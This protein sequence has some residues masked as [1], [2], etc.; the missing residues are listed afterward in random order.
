MTATDHPAAE[1][2]YGDGPTASA[3]AS[4]TGPTGDEPVRTDSS[5]RTDHPGRQ[6]RILGDQGTRGLL[7][8]SGAYLVL[9]V[10]LWWNVWSTHPTS[11]TTCGCGDSSLFT[12]FL[13]WPAYALSHGLNPLYSTALF[14]PTGVN[15]LSNTAE[16]GLGVVL[17]PVTWLFGPVATLNVSLTLSPL[18]SALAMFVLVRRWVY[19]QPAAFVAG[20]LYGFSPFVLIALTDA[21][22]MLAMAP[23]APLVVICLDELLVRQTRSPVWTGVVLGLL[24]TV[25]FFIGTEVLVLMVIAAAVGVALMALYG[26]WHLQVL[27]QRARHA[28]VALVTAGVT[29]G[30]L[31]IYPVWFAL[32]GPAHL[33][34]PV[35]G[36]DSHLGDGGTNVHDYLL[37][38]APSAT[39]TSLA[40]RLGGYQAPTLSAQYFGIGLLAVLMAGLVL[41]RRDRRLWLFAAVG[42]ISVPLSFGLQPHRWTLWRLFV[43]FPLMENII[44][45][46]FLLITYL[47]AAVM[48]GIIVD[49]TFRGVSRWITATPGDRHPAA[50][51]IARRGAAAIA[52]LMVAAI[53]LGPIAGYFSSG[54]PLTAEPVVVPTW[55]RT[56][57]PHLRGHQVLLVFPV[58]FALLQSAMTWQ[59]VDGMSFSMVGGGGP[60]SLPSRAGN[61]RAGQNYL[62]NVSI[63]GGPQGVTPQEVAAVRQALDGW[64]VTM[65]VIPDPDNLPIYERLHLVRTTAVLIT[66]ATGQPPI[67]QAGAWV[68]TRVNHA[69]PPVAASA[70]RLTLC[71]AGPPG[72]SVA[73]IQR[74]TACVVATPASPSTDR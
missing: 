6:S 55:F 59:S 52:A 15:L 58:P 16:V 13:E 60:G 41:W 14:H 22:L 63:A 10:L 64:G 31:L 44:P 38:G 65:V 54:V 40:H 20:L 17:S 56:A 71:G 19:W 2:A 74:S 45:S 28:L 30:V 7:I 3:T 51:A 36:P 73:S 72:G 29:A 48:L 70:T 57:G 61:E 23:I 69:G 12:W 66:A 33:S 68:W 67:R 8:A 11:T 18:L 37:P 62:G 27:L 47:C 25:E 32:A 5:V 9:A 24:V 50:P 34:G 53:A 43:R 39:F 1:Q 35:W 21:H 26:L 42:V 4:A 49:R 46:R